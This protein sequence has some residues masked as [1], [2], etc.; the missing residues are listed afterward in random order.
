VVVIAGWGDSD[1]V[2]TVKAI[3]EDLT[4]NKIPILEAL[5]GHGSGSYSNEADVREPDFQTTFFGPN[6]GRLS[7]IKEVYD[8]HALFI[9]GAGV[10]SENW[11]AEGLCKV[12]KSVGRQGHTD[13]TPGSRNAFTNANRYSFLGQQELPNQI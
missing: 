4:Q 8:P 1:S 2:D 6:Y 3:R 11:D 9:V 10:G 7:A 5:A 12:V 13:A